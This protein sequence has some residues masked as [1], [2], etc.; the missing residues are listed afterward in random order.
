L[1]K[2]TQE[3]TVAEEEVFTAAQLRTP[4]PRLTLRRLP[5]GFHPSTQCRRET[6]AAG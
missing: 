5:V 2:Q 1:F 6:S 4:L 3:A